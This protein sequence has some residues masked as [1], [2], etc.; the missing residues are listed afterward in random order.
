MFP[1]SESCENETLKVVGT[2]E[3]TQQQHSSE[4]A[5]LQQ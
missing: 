1:Y 2:V 4:A 5:Y 3:I